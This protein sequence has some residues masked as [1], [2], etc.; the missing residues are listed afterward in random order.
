MIPK[1]SLDSRID[2]SRK[3]SSQSQSMTNNII[4]NSPVDRSDSSEEA[5]R[6]PRGSYPTVYDFIQPPSDPEKF[7]AVEV[8]GNELDQLLKENKLF[9]E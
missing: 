7:E 4:I 8:K 1:I 3:S 6:T 2:E 9:K 5:V